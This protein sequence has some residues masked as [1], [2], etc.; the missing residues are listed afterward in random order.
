M[1]AQGKGE[2]V[3]SAIARSQRFF[4]YVFRVT[5]PDP[6]APGFVS[7]AGSIS[8]EFCSGIHQNSLAEG[9]LGE[10]HYVSCC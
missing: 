8:D 1:D 10:I 3:A 6:L 7:I 9:F 4:V 2:N 5:I